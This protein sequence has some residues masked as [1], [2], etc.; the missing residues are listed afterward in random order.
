LDK[1]ALRG[2]SA[3]SIQ[4]CDFVT[5]CG[6]LAAIGM[7]DEDREPTHK[8]SFPGPARFTF[9]QAR[10]ATFRRYGVFSPFG[11]YID[12]IAGGNWDL[13]HPYGFPLVGLACDGQLLAFPLGGIIR[14]RAD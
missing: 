2:R 6:Q 11:V 10:D 13:W 4:I 14:G 1:K 8:P 3:G 5:A 12:P 7:T 9:D